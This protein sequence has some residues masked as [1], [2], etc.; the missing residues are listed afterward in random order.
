[1]KVV[2]HNV[3]KSKGQRK[4]NWEVVLRAKATSAIGQESENIVRVVLKEILRRESGGWMIAVVVRRLEMV[5]E[6]YLVVVVEA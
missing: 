1:V 5:V 3:C 6:G 4:G 2:V